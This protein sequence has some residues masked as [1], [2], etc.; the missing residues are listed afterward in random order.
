MRSVGISLAVSVAVAPR[1][2]ERSICAHQ[3]AP[4]GAR[5]TSKSWSTRPPTATVIRTGFAALATGT[6]GTARSGR[7]HFGLNRAIGPLSLSVS[8]PG[9]GGP[10]AVEDT[11]EQRPRVVAHDDRL[12]ARK[13]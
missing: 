7:R 11:G 9:H 1:W 10:R 3:S 13:A 5:L 2:P 4:S 6:G 8:C 12:A